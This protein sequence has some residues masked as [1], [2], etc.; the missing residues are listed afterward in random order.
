MDYLRDISTFLVGGGFIAYLAKYAFDRFLAIG[1]EKHKNSL[2]LELE[3]FK[4]NYILELERFKEKL[5]ESAL[6]HKVKFTQL[7]EERAAII[8]ELYQRILNLGED[9]RDQTIALGVNGFMSGGENPGEPAGS[10]ESTANVTN[11][12]G[13]LIIDI[14][15]N[16]LIDFYHYFLQKRIY[17]SNELIALIDQLFEKYLGQIQYALNL[18]SYLKTCRNGDGPN[19]ACDLE[20]ISIDINQTVEVIGRLEERVIQEFQELLGVK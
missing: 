6:E 1:V 17:F 2:T 11:G 19:F 16:E 9:L 20:R 7:H 12:N 15:T 14:V 8:K 5:N 18:R 13:S 3:H 10:A 4:H